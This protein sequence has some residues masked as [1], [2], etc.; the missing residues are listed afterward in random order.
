MHCQSFLM[1]VDLDVLSDLA[2]TSTTA[3]EMC[4]ALISTA[5]PEYSLLLLSNRDEFLGR[6][7]AFVQRWEAPYDQVL[8][9]QD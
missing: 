8:G 7:T 9:G 3:I 2:H 6:P 5:H 1:T 4:T